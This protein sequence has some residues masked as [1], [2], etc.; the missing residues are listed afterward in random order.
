MG[1]KMTSISRYKL[2]MNK[3]AQTVVQHDACGGEVHQH[4][5]TADDSSFSAR[6]V[7][8]NGLIN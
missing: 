6:N 2:T 7:D 5:H 1:M 4:P 3:D 8:S